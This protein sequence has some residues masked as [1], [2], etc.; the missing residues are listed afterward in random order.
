MVTAAA[1]LA[2]MVFSPGIGVIVDRRG[3]RRQPMVILA[4]TAALSWALFATTHSLTAILLLTFMAGG[5]W[6]AI[7]PVGDS[8]AMMV[9]ARENLDYGRVRLWGSA[10]FI[11]AAVAVGHVLTIA[12]SALLVWLIVGWLVATAIAC[13]LLPDLRSVSEGPAAPFAPL[14]RSRPFLLFVACAAAN[15]AAHTAYYAFSTLHW[16]QAGISDDII[17]LLW[18]E[19]VIAEIILFSISGKVVERMGPAGLLV[20]A[21]MGGVVRWLVLGATTALPA[22]AAVQILHAATFGCAH[23]GAMHFLQ[24]AVPQD[25]SVRAQGL[26]ASIALGAVPGLMSPLTGAL[27]ERFGGGSFTAMALFSLT[28]AILALALGQRWHG[29]KVA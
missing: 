3:D 7:I 15:Q 6:A 19:G 21:G 26:Y 1:Y 11:L 14:L 12:P 27:F 22:L 8:L 13:S 25:L 24:R 17:G 28:A 18:S 29:G 4:I 10:A 9:S 2:R 16:R 20:A 23:L 5:L